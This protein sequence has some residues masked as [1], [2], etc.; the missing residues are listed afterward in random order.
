MQQNATTASCNNRKPQ[1]WQ[2]LQLSNILS[3]FDIFVPN[4]LAAPNRHLNYQR[5]EII[6]LILVEGFNALIKEGALS[7]T[8]KYF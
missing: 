6:I 2:T 5:L 1:H 8:F 4:P 3:R 7:K